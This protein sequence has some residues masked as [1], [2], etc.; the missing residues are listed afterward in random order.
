MAKVLARVEKRASKEGTTSYTLMD[1]GEIVKRQVVV[2]PVIWA[3][4]EVIQE[5]PSR[6]SETERVT[7]FVKT[8]AANG[9]VWVGA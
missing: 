3:R 8:F 7:L 5:P 9:Y 1:N 6:L 2:G 4:R